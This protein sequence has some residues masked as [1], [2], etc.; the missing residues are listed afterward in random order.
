MLGRGRRQAERTG[1]PWDLL[2]LGLGNPGER[3]AGT[4]H[5]VGVDVVDELARRHD[6]RLKADSRV[7]ASVAEVRIDGRRVVLAVPST[8]M[9]DSGQAAGPLVRRYGIADPRRLVVVHDELDLEQGRLKVKDGGG[10][11]GHNGLRSID[12]HLHTTDFLRI[13]LGVGK[14]PGGPERGADWVLSKVPKRQRSELDVMVA[15]AAD[16][17]ECIATD[18]P[19]VAMQRFNARA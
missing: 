17:V 2:V 18:G 19:D 11:A 16:A 15:E 4:R 12:A 14:P 10:L 5:N 1:S 7:N 9:N 8:Y 6:G 13:R 3:Y